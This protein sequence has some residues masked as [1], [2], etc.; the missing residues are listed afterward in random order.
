MKEIHGVYSM[1]FMT[2]DKLIGVRDPYG[3]RPLILGKLG[4]KYYISSESCALD[5]IGC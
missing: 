2:E 5:A 1:I 3:I 4:D